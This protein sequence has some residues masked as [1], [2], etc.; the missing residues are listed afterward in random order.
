MECICQRQSSS[1]YQCHIDYPNPFHQG[2][3][4]RDISLNAKYLV[5]LN[6]VRD[7]NQFSHL[8]CQVY[9]EGPNQHFKAYLNATKRPY[10]YLVL[11]LAQDTDDRLMFRTRI[12]PDEYHPTFYVDVNDETDKIELSHP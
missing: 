1:E 5:F 9:P 2:R 10:G 8:A 6:N 11:Y 3:F 7:K 12:F 4:Y